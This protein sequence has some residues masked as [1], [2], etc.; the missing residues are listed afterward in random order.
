MKGKG[1]QVSVCHK[2]T[3]ELQTC[4]DLLLLPNPSTVQG[5]RWV[6]WES[7]HANGVQ[8]CPLGEIC[9]IYSFITSSIP[10]DEDLGGKSPQNHT[11]SSGSRAMFCP[12]CSWS[13]VVS[14]GEAAET[15]AGRHYCLS[16]PFSC[17]GP[18]WLSDCLPPSCQP[19]L[20]LQAPVPLDPPVSRPTG[21][22]WL[23]TPCFYI[24]REKMKAEGHDHTVVPSDI[25][26]SPSRVAKKFPSR[27]LGEHAGCSL[28]ENLPP[29]C[30]SPDCSLKG[31]SD[32]HRRRTPFPTPPPVVHS[33]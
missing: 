29:S 28:R 25:S 7:L 24:L 8:I 30:Q 15:A 23:S 20:V 16:L 6:G 1:R 17:M 3:P 22:L 18:R 19:S 21:V 12:L 32:I 4:L 31:K 13:S 5:D 2:F 10:S 26:S 14:L 27:P 11:G 33:G 9:V